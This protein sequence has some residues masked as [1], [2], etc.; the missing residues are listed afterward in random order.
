MDEKYDPSN[1]FIKGLNNNKWYK[2][3]KEE[4]KSQSEETIA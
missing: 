4:S 2:I 3:Y 1:L